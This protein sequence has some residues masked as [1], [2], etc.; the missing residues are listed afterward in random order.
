MRG[1]ISKRV[2]RAVVFL[3]GHHSRP[4]YKEEE[5]MYKNWGKQNQQWGG[6]SPQ[7]PK[8]V[9]RGRK[10]KDKGGKDANAVAVPYDA[11][12]SPLPSSSEAT[13]NEAAFVKEFM[14]YMK[15]NK[16]EIPDQL[17]KLLPDTAREDI[18]AK[19]KKLNRHR[20]LINKLDAKRAAVEKDNEKWNCW[21]ESIKTEIT[22]QK[23]KHQE[24]QKQLQKEIQELEEEERRL[25]QVDPEAEEEEGPMNMDTEEMVDSLINEGDG[26]PK[27]LNKGDKHN[28]AVEMMQVQMERQFQMMQIENQKMQ[29]FYEHKIAEL[30]KAQKESK[31]AVWEMSDGEEKNVEPPMMNSVPPRLG[32]GLGAALVGLAKAGADTAPFGVQKEREDTKQM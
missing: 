25:R 22:N 12:S 8:N 19:Q 15:V 9:N 18:K 7:M 11:S 23:T 29:Q 2:K 16:A 21:L 3:S 24:T 30:Q 26:T 13:S 4:R 14:E 20:T 27:H 1:R 32:P 17:R 5:V 10:E 31:D 28:V 6:W